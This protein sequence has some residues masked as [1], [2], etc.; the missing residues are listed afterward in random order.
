MRICDVGIDRIQYSYNHDEKSVNKVVEELRKLGVVAFRDK[1]IDRDVTAKIHGVW[2]GIEVKTGVPYNLAY[3][4]KWHQKKSILM[5]VRGDSVYVV[6]KSAEDY[7]RGI[8]TLMEN[9]E[10]NKKYLSKY[11]PS[12]VQEEAMRYVPFTSKDREELIK[13]RLV[14]LGEWISGFKN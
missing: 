10:N 9:W 1:R 3:L 8:R 7:L 14:R 5:V 13:N 11:I 12:N 6:K 2:V 4:F